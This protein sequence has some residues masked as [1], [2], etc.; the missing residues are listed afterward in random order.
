MTSLESDAGRSMRAGQIG[1]V[2]ARLSKLRTHIDAALAELANAD[3][4]RLAGTAT[5]PHADLP[6]AVSDLGVI[7]LMLGLQEEQETAGSRG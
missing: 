6:E 7:G 3:R 1:D 5:P 2:A 4:A